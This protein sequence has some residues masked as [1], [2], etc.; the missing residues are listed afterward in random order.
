[1]LTIAT[2][3]E[4]EQLMSSDKLLSIGH[5]CEPREENI[6]DFIGRSGRDRGESVNTTSEDHLH[7]QR[8][9][10]GTGGQDKLWRPIDQRSNHLE[11]PATFGTYTLNPIHCMTHRAGSHTI[12]PPNLPGSPRDHSQFHP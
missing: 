12:S 11:Q 1:M 3:A 8:A 4:S 6:D 7:R 9:R 10:G 5:A 2:R